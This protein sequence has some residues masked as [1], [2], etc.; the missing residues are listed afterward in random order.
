MYNRRKSEAKISSEMRSNPEVHIF[1]GCWLWNSVSEGSPERCSNNEIPSVVLESEWSTFT[2]VCPCLA[3]LT[4][5]SV[6][7]WLL[8]QSSVAL[9]LSKSRKP[10][11]NQ[12]SEMES[13]THRV[14]IWCVAGAIDIKFNIR[15]FRPNYS[16]STHCFAVNLCLSTTLKNIGFMFLPLLFFPFCMPKCTSYLN[17]KEKNDSMIFER[18]VIVFKM[19][20]KL[21]DIF[22]VLAF[23]KPRISCVLSAA[24]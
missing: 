7:Y 2:D 5:V 21:N 23:P 10:L 3:S 8:Q 18:T 9:L 19:S 17:L 4:A 6:F 24:F 14:S 12:L 15:L 16:V 22:L 20:I 11:Q 13:C 1:Q